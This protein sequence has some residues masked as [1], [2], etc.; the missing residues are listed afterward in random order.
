[1]VGMDGVSEASALGVI[2]TA[3]ACV[4]NAKK[5]A[6]IMESKVL[7]GPEGLR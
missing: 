1:M 4:A 3:E 7:D 6:T 2:A 5:N